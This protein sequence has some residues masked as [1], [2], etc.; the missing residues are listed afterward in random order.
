MTSNN[1]PTYL[2]KGQSRPEN[3]LGQNN[4]IKVHTPY[5]KGHYKKDVMNEPK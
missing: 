2:K 3:Q 1:V 5:P 4:S